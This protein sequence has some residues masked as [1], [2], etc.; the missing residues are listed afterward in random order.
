M[1][2]HTKTM[3]AM[4]VAVAVVLAGCETTGQSAGA[5]AGLGAVAG[6]IIGNQSGNAAEGALIGAVVGGLGGLIVHDVKERRQR[7]REETVAQY[8]D[9]T[10]TQPTEFLRFE[11]STVLPTSARPGDRVESN[12]QYALLGT[13]AGLQVTETRTLHPGDRQLST[14]TITRDDGTWVS[15]QEFQ[16]PPDQPRGTYTIRTTVATAGQSISGDAQFVVR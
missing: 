12:I 1:K 13:G 9:Y 7:S 4:L 3:G 14:R 2:K 15:S 8:P 10:P 11:S 16:L 5:G 6:A